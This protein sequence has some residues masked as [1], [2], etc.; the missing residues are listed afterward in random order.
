MLPKV[1]K[2]ESFNFP[3]L[4]FSDINKLAVGQPVMSIGNSINGL[5]QVVYGDIENMYKNI[6][7]EDDVNLNMVKFKS[8]IEHSS[9]MP[10]GFSGSPLVDEKGEVLGM[11]IAI[12]KFSSDRNSSYAINLGMIRSFVEEFNR[13]NHK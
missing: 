5:W 6:I 7:V 13:K 2:N 10:K 8:I 1:S 9:I 11:N 12:S 3:Y 4:K